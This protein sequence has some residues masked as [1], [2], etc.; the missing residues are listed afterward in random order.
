MP[1]VPTFPIVGFNPTDTFSVASAADHVTSALIEATH[2][3]TEVAEYLDCVLD[4][5]AVLSDVDRET[6]AGYAHQA[7][8]LAQTLE[9]MVRRAP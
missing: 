5:T 8:D 1:Y 2:S 7:R 3:A 6:V 9:A 4:G